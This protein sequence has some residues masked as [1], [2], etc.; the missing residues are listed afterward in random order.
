MV[1]PP[2][3]RRCKD[4]PPTGKP[5]PAPYPGPRCH[6]H[7]R[8]ELKRKREANRARNTAR[9]FG[10][11][12]A[13]KEQVRQHQGGGCICKPWT[14]YDGSG[15]RALST[16]HDHKTGIIRGVLCKHCNDLL[17]RVRDDPEYFRRMN[18]YLANPPA[19]QVLGPRQ[20][21]EQYQTST[22]GQDCARDGSWHATPHRRCALRDG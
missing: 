20:V 21:P 12:P 14:G 7:N 17:G 22:R 2:K 8:A 6:T 1:S 10:I 16:D 15:K 9:R 19:V 3:P 5:R 4:C 18:E 11:T 13:E